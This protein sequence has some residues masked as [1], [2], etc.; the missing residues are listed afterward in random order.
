VVGAGDV[1][2]GEAGLS[3]AQVHVDGLFHLTG[4]TTISSHAVYFGSGYMLS[5]SPLSIVGGFPTFNSGRMLSPSTLSLSSG[6]LS[7]SDSMTVTGAVELTGGYFTGTGVIAS[8]GTMALGSLIMLSGTLENHGHVTQTAF[9]QI[10]SNAVLNNLPG[11]VFD[12]EG[13]GIGTLNTPGTHSLNNEGVFR[14]SSNSGNAVVGVSFNNSGTVEVHSGSLSILGPG[15]HTGA[16]QVDTGATLEFGYFGGAPHLLTASSQITGAGNL[17]LSASADVLGAMALGGTVTVTGGTNTFSGSFSNISVLSILAGRVDFNTTQRVTVNALSLSAGRVN[18]N[19]TQPVAFGQLNVAG[20]TLATGDPLVVLGPTMWTGGMLDVDKIN[21]LGSLNLAGGI[22]ILNGG[23]LNNF[24]AATW[25]SGSI[26]TGAGSLIS[27]APFA[28]FSITFDG[29]TFAGF[30]GSRAFWN[31]GLLRKTGGTGQATI[32]DAVYNTGTI[33]GQ[34]G[35]LAFGNTFIQ[36]TGATLL[37]GGNIAAAGPLQIQGGRLAGSGTVAATVLNSGRCGPGGLLRINR[38]YTQTSSGHLDIEL[39]PG[40][41]SDQLQVSG[42]ASLDGALNVT[43]L[44]G[45]RPAFDQSF[46]VLT[47]ASR[48]G[49]FSVLNDSTL[50]ELSRSYDPTGLNLIISQRPL[51]ISR[52]GGQLLVTWPSGASDYVLQG[53]TQLPAINWLDLASGTNAFGLSRDQPAQFFR[54]FKP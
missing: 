38:N 47:F 29:Q 5:N 51:A 20:G 10:A 11:A 53:T 32:S 42:S 50:S 54:L 13:S 9:T 43:T 48:R 31:A 1:V 34:S 21:I 25:S 37:A 14:K 19:T 52:Q 8:R 7:G 22:L 24:G 41:S 23:T 44:G 4:A 33:A 35:T 6:T 12:Y 2:F 18:F 39:G 45:F 27:N 46:R 15:T 36:A 28:S 17:A 26:F 3:G 16:F 40:S 30:G 49:D